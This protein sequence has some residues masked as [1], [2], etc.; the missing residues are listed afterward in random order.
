MAASA[1][2]PHD[3]IQNGGYII[4]RNGRV[5]E[6][7]HADKLF[8]PASTIK[9][10]TAFTALKTLGD[11]FKFI[12]SFYLDKNQILYVEGSG[13]PTLTTESL[14][15]IAQELK[16]KGVTHVSGYVLDG[17]TFQLEHQLPDGSEN[18]I[19]PYDVANSGLAV[20]FNSISITKHKDGTI[21]S[22]EE[23][24]PLTPLGREIAQQLPPGKHRV[25][26][27]AFK[28]GQT[29]P[30]PL[31]YTGELLHAVLLQEGISSQ[32]TMRQGTATKQAKLIYQ[33]T[34]A[35][36][37]R[38]IVKSCLYVSNNFMANQ[39]ALTAGAV[40]YGYPATWEKSRRLLQH[41]ATHKIGISPKELQVMEGSGLSR[42]T[43]IT[44]SAMLNILKVF[45]QYRELLP[46]RQ[47]FL[48]KSGTM[49]NVYCY[50]GY[51]D[52]V[53]GTVLFAVLLNQQENIRQIML[54]NLKQNFLPHISQNTGPTHR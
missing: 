8:I 45:E 30:Q 49:R 16:R 18:S 47:G 14:I 46:E 54:T 38:E 17:S 37:V 12:T 52:S 48:L 9:L 3:K 34:S 31:R 25:N 40:Q 13:D 53:E 28:L 42:G 23:L 19:N 50:A 26:I 44:A 10:L 6:Q 20:N 22:P 2:L 41:Y 27:N 15:E 1:V 21:S 35:Q 32:P 24:T 11:D 51:L 33:H 29:L 7:Y 5:I 43:S 36:S 4:F 39:L